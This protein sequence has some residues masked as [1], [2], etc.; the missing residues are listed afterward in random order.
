M[1]AY[2]LTDCING[3]TAF[4]FADKERQEKITQVQMTKKSAC[5]NLPPAEI[6]SQD[7]CRQ[8]ERRATQSN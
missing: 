7:V 3:V 2:K 4:L 1:N 8:G 5:T 6:A